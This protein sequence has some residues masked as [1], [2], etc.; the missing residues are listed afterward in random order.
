MRAVHPQTDLVPECEYP[1]FKR[2]VHVF[3]PTRIKIPCNMCNTCARIRA[4]VRYVTLM[5]FVE[6]VGA[7]NL[8]M[9]TLT[10]PGGRFR[11]LPVEDR[12]VHFLLAK[13]LLAEQI[14]REN[15][16]R[17]KAGVPD[18]IVWSWV[19]EPQRD[20]TPHLHALISKDFAPE[21]EGEGRPRSGAPR[22]FARWLAS[23]GFG[24][25]Y[26]SERVRHDGSGAA[27]YLCKYL[28]K[29]AQY[30]PE[31]KLPGRRSKPRMI[32]TVGQSLG[33][34]PPGD[35]PPP[36]IHD[37]PF[38]DDDPRDLPSGRDRRCQETSPE[39][40]RLH[41]RRIRREL[42]ARN[43]WVLDPL[44]RETV[45]DLEREYDRLRCQYVTYTDELGYSWREL[46]PDSIDVEE[47][48]EVDAALEDIAPRVTRKVRKWLC[49]YA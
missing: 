18:L 20:G 39:G 31:W 46:D 44:L 23:L 7:Q 43:P 37:G 21:Y 35:E 19:V 40:R 34:A 28:T 33:Y 22:A 15:T 1:F 47:L 16:R 10:M 49:R 4:G 8:A 17:R 30:P 9:L 41:N 29:T 5:R 14:N 42:L 48:V 36:Y 13:Q 32:R 12:V 27:Y 26:R 6:G 25:V 11:L 2:L 45:D 38:S 3:G 24:E